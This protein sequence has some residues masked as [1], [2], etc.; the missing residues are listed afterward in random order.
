LKLLADK[1]K[2]ARSLD[3]SKAD[4]TQLSYLGS[5]ICGLADADIEKITGAALK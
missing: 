1:Y 2:T 3:L 4:D 5:F